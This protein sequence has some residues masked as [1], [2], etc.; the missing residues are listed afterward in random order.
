[1]VKIQ[2]CATVSLNNVYRCARRIVHIVGVRGGDGGTIEDGTR[3]LTDVLV[4]L[5]HHIHAIL[6]HE[7]LECHGE[8]PPWHMAGN[9]I[10]VHR[11]NGPVQGEEQPGVLTAVAGCKLGLD[12][13]PLGGAF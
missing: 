7:W 10:I 4:A 8:G 2:V 5:E 3:S 12:E 1:M 6:A 11:V 13:E 9:L